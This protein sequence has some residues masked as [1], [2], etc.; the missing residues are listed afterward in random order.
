MRRV[1]S[2]FALQLGLEMR[3]SAAWG[4][5]LWVVER[6][7]RCYFRTLLSTAQIEEA[8]ELRFVIADRAIREQAQ[9]LAAFVACGIHELGLITSMKTPLD[10]ASMHSALD[11]TK[12]PPGSPYAVTAIIVLPRTREN[13]KVPQPRW[14]GPS[15]FRSG[16][17]NG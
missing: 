2:H 11:R 7:A 9:C 8:T 12:A 6:P 15:P 4:E 17:E 13:S 16:Q 14:A 10:A 5:S 3:I 1:E